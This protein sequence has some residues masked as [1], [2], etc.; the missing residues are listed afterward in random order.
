MIPLI[1][2]ALNDIASTFP[3]FYLDITVPEIVFKN[4]RPSIIYMKL[5]DQSGIY[6]EI[7]KKLFIRFKD[8]PNIKRA[9]FMPHI[10][11]GRVK[12]AIY[13]NKKINLQTS[14]IDS[15]FMVRSIELTQS[16]LTPIGPLYTTL[17]SSEVLHG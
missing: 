17:Y 12:G 2:E 7:Y 9:S 8:I 6:R 10:T 1:T 16:T 14:H 11:L 3:V 5:L 4:K 15:L 13:H